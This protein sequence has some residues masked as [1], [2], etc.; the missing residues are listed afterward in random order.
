VYP[1]YR[2]QV[3]LEV[4]ILA[5]FLR[6]PNPID[7]LGL[8]TSRTLA[9]ARTLPFAIAQIDQ[10]DFPASWNTLQKKQQAGPV[11]GAPQLTKPASQSDSYLNLVIEL[12]RNGSFKIIKATLI[13]GKVVVPDFPTSN[14]L[15]E[16]TSGHMTL[17]I[18]FFPEDPF[19]V[20]GFA[21]SQNSQERIANGQSATVV[22]NIPLI[23]ASPAAINKI[24]LGIIKLVSHESTGSL[25]S[26]V[27]AKLKARRRAILL[28][29]LPASKLAPA[30]R[31]ILVKL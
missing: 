7:L 21:D 1:N 4:F 25:N 13:P 8:A 5:I 3:V 10:L 17:A 18:G 6:T 27:L 9:I 15:Y 24:H 30:I 23:D 29:D 2:R 14:F 11:P 28:N 12:R 31:K 16:A 26:A 19:M 20:R 22:V